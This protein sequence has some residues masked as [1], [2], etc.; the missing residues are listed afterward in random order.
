MRSPVSKPSFANWGKAGY[1]SGMVR[2]RT[3]SDQDVLAGA[4]LVVARQ[5]PAGATLAQVGAEVGLSAAAL[6]KRFG[7]KRGMLLALARQGAD[8][9]PARILAAGATPAP[10]D[11]LIDVLAGLAGAVRTP[12]EFANHL[13]FLLLDLSDPE[14]QQITRRYASATETALAA[15]LRAGQASGRLVDGDPQVLAGLV[16]AT[17]NGALITWGMLGR[18][19]LADHVRT[20]LEH[21]L[22]PYRTR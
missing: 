3:V 2:P 16:H 4:A 1:G 6:V 13:A 19:A 12:E 20:Q 10:V 18:G 22:D 14:F 8:V 5:G 9:L 11:A 7:S 17:Y 15:A 21:L